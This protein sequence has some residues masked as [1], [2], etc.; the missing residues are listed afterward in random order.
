MLVFITLSFAFDALCDNG[1]EF[2]DDMPEVAS[3]AFFS[4]NAVLP[5]TFGVLFE[6]LPLLVSEISQT[7][8]STVSLTCKSFVDG[9]SG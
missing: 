7:A 8:F 5:F 9:N 1:V 6:V 2:D 3:F 4:H